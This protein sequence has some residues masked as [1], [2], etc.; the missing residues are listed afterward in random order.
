MYIHFTCGCTIINPFPI[1]MTS[2]TE[3]PSVISRNPNQNSIGQHVYRSKH[4]EMCN[5][6]FTLTRFL[7]ESIRTIIFWVNSVSLHYF[8]FIIFR[9]KIVLQH[10]I[11]SVFTRENDRSTTLCVWIN[12]NLELFYHHIIMRNVPVSLLFQ[13]IH[14][15][16][17]FVSHCIRCC[18]SITHS[19]YL[20]N[21][22]FASLF[23][24]M[25]IF[26]YPFAVFCFGFDSM[27]CVFISTENRVFSFTLLVRFFCFRD[28]LELFMFSECDPKNVY[29]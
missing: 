8:A 20:L 11:K 25:I 9:W 23:L 24:M 12:K 29:E 15:L 13:F 22:V 4:N 3:K 16:P 19:S 10:Q 26:I 17:L 21:C 18:S 5:L 1:A 7:F 6:F 2:Q 27:P 28:S 14:F